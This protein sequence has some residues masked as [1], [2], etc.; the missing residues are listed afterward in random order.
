MKTVWQSSCGIQFTEITTAD[1][2]EQRKQTASLYI[3]FV[4]IKQLICLKPW[5]D[6][7]LL[8][9]VLSNLDYHVTSRKLTL[10]ML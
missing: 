4:E 5:D 10:Y 6:A 3:A 7:S 8:P 2:T 9:P 1:T